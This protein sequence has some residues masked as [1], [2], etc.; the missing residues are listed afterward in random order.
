M[1]T[2]LE[3]IDMQHPISP[4]SN[5][6][7]KR[8]RKRG[9]RS[10]R[11]CRSR[12]IK[13]NRQMPCQ[14]C[15]ASG[16]ESQCTYNLLPPPSL[17]SH[18]TGIVNHQSIQPKEAAGLQPL[19]VNARTAAKQNDAESD[20]KHRELRA[21]VAAFNSDTQAYQFYGPS[22]HFSFVQRLY[23]RMKR[24]SLRPLIMETHRSIPEG[25]QHWGVDKQMFSKHSDAP[26][27]QGDISHTNMLPRHVG[28]SFIAEYFAIVHPQAPILVEAEIARTWRALFDAPRR[29][30]T[31]RHKIA[32][33]RSILYMVLAIGACLSNSDGD[34]NPG[35]WS[36]FF[37]ERSSNCGECFIDTSLGG[38]HLALLRAIYAMQVGRSNWIYL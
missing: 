38:T 24:Q 18:R 20:E 17:Q 21:G 9:I 28:D 14:R 11:P 31:D 1:A 2:S 22:S 23:Q 27:N 26:R 12:K 10:C 25:L 35:N 33:E 16:K 29:D 4:V 19:A 6:Q 5:L 15:V 37:F 13:C 3:L 34:E 36:D 32:I 7:P 8:V 30:P